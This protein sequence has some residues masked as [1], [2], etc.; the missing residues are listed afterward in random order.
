MQDW[1][2]AFMEWLVEQ[3]DGQNSDKTGT[4]YEEQSVF[5]P[6]STIHHDHWKRGISHAFNVVFLISG[7]L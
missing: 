6:I 5:L 4:G 7:C 3:V 2:S 1:P